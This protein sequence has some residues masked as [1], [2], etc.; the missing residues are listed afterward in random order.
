MRQSDRKDYAGPALRLV[1]A[2]FSQ[3]LHLP[4]VGRDG[5]TQ[6][7]VDKAWDDI[8]S[9]LEQGAAFIVAGQAW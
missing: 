8:V 7:D 9:R 2:I 6:A 3:F 5:A 4:I 1:Q